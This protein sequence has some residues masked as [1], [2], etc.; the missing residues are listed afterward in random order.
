MKRFVVLLATFATAAALWACHDEH[1]HP[2]TAPAKA[3]DTPDAHDGHTHH[4]HDSGP[5]EMLGLVELEG[6]EVSAVQTGKLL[7]GE[8]LTFD[9]E[10]LG[11]EKPTGVQFWIGPA[12]GSVTTEKKPPEEV[13]DN[14]YHVDFDLPAT[15]PAGARLWVE[16]ERASGSSVRVAFEVKPPG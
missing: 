15:I 10:I 2:A 7:A 4:H 9:V 12:D 13:K 8:E 5:K 6:F 11:K 1:D 14:V 3:A 16:I